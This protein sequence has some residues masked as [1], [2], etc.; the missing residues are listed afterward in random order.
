MPNSNVRRTQELQK[1]LRKESLD[2]LVI[3]NPADWYYLSGF[4]GEA[5]ILIVGPRHV[6]LVTD[7]RFTVQAA[8]ELRGVT[9]VEQK[10]GLHR[11]CGELLKNLRAKRVGFDPNQVTV[12]HCQLLK[13]AAGKGTQFK[14]TAGLV[15]SLRARKDA[16]ELAQMRK[17]ALLASEVVEY[18][19]G[20]LKPGVR[21]FEVAAEVEYQMR[22]RGASGAAF[23]SIV[24]FGVRGALPHARP[25]AK[26]LRKNEL[27]VLDLGAILGKYCSDITR[28]VYVGKAPAKVRLWYQAVLE[29]QKAAID[30]IRP[31][32][33]AGEVDAAA[34]RVLAAYRLDQYFV[35]STGHG[36][37]L[38]VHEDPR[39][40]K[41]QKTQLASGNVITIEPG[42]YIAG[43]GGIR[44][45]DDV[46]V[47]QGHGE[48]LTRASRDFT[49]I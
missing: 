43:V 8:E 42:V 4:T 9:V 44:I 18:A 25:T 40:A 3:T 23:E 30:A 19:I 11:S 29:A 28:T 47:Q 46:V 39:L 12:R 2:A 26:R 17:A 33:S 16:T 35:H 13:K 48:V 21:E 5:G 24:A 32:K 20:L 1:L 31:G 45:E 15:A 10:E 22:K 49:E 7:G 36:L 41:G 37:G 38:E 34:R 6:T 14:E 27:V